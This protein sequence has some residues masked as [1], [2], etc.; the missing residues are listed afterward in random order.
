M[1]IVFKDRYVIHFVDNAGSLSHLVNGYAGRADS[2]KIVNMFHCAIM[3]LGMTWWGEW[4]PSKANIAD[5]MTRPERFHELLKGLGADA[6]VKEY[7]LELPPLGASAATLR[8]W[9]RTMRART[10]ERESSA[11]S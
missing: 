2:A 8:D 7:D 3:A 1:P 10:Q 9:M 5:I 4:V 6:I 11:R